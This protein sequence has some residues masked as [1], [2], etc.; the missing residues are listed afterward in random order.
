[1]STYP[2]TFVFFYGVMCVIY[3]FVSVNLYKKYQQKQDKTLMLYLGYALSLCAGG[4]MGIITILW[5]TKLGPI[6]TLFQLIGMTSLFLAILN[7]IK[8]WKLWPIPVALTTVVALFNLII[9]DL[10]NSLTLMASFLALM[11]LTL[12]TIIFSLL[13]AK[14]QNSPTLF[15]IGIGLVIL[16]VGGIVEQQVANPIV[17]K[18][19]YGCLII[20]STLTMSWGFLK[21]P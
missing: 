16:I 5:L 8:Q 11:L 21:I 12:P 4:G 14:K 1:M 9:Y 2:I 13:L 6:L 19:I 15:S 17:A 20:L 10:E 18:N 7:Q 3:G